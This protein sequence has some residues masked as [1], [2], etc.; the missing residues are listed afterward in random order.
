MTVRTAPRPRSGSEIPA[1]DPA[2][3]SLIRT[4]GLLK[5]V[6]EP[7][8][9]RH[10]ISLAQWGVLRALT[11]AE[12]EGLDGVRLTDLS[13]RLLV[14]PPSVTGVIDRLQRMKLVE[15]EASTSDHRSKLVRLTA[16]GRQ[17]VARVRQGH[18]ARVKRVLEALTP[19][20][21]RQLRRLLDRL[22]DHLELLDQQNG[23]A[24]LD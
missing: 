3:R 6:M 4:L 15:R 14:R 19:A 23:V 1:I 8:F 13:E 20:E 2:F 21:Q 22:A 18:G 12:D 5:R 11:R 7:Y 9:A 17:R 16:S 10:G 24:D